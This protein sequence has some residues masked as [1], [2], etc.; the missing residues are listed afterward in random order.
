MSNILESLNP[1]Q[2]RAATIIDGPLLILAGAG[3]GKTKTITHRIAYMVKE[4]NIEP[5]SILAVTFTNKA[6]KEM[7]DRI[8]KLIGNDAKYMS[9]STFHSFG[10]KLLR[11]YGEKIGYDKNFNIYDSGDQQRILRKIM[12]NY[13]IESDSFK[14]AKIASKISNLKEQGIEPNEYESIA[15]NYYEECVSEI[16]VEYQ[17][18]LRKNN[19][20]DF[21]DILVYTKKLMENEEVLEKIQKKYK[22]VMIDEYQDTNKM[23]Y[24]I[25]NKIA[26]KNK[27]LCVVGDEDQSIYGFRGADI[28]NILN[29]ELDYKNTEVIKLERNYRSTSIILEAANILIKNNKTSKGKKLWTENNRGSKIKLFE[30]ED[31]REEAAYVIKEIKKLSEETYDYKDFCILYRTNAQSR[32][33]EDELRVNNINYKIFGGI[34]FYQRKEIKD[35]MAFL[36]V[37]NNISDDMS[38]MRIMEMYCQGVGEK[39]IEKIEEFAEKYSKGLYF[40]MQEIENIKGVNGKAKLSLQKLYEIITEGR[41]MSKESGVEEII[42]YI[43]KITKYTEKLK[44]QNEEEKIANVYELKNSIHDM[45]KINGKMNLG[46]YLEKISLITSVDDLEEDTNYVKLMT[47]H[48]SKGLEFPVVFVV[49]MEDELFPGKIADID[50]DRVEEERRLCYVA[51]TRAEERLY[52]T[53]ARSRI[54]YN[55]LS[56]MR[57]PSRFICEIPQDYFETEKI[58]LE[59]NGYRNNSVKSFSELKKE[60]E[61]KKD[62]AADDYL[63]KIGQ[64]VTHKKFGE[65]KVKHIEADKDKIK[66][67]FPGYGEKEFKGSAL[68]KFLV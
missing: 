29:F 35:I 62:V 22:Y 58:Y 24:D 8:E 17:K 54:L 23:Q 40:A 45:E 3:S 1:E 20:M 67:F 27:N 68:N 36:N 31:A 47:I 61:N 52:F 30:G 25:V 13:D 34:Q 6:A 5:G 14:P 11:V 28:R 49:G 42:D 33:F 51:I 63:Y 65:G 50:D 15:S 39:T 66:I 9:V 46:E 53:H 7:K 4:K 44:L 10:V 59:M 43:L 57:E 37:I 12:K 48:N 41:Y 2:R 55:T 19:S 32:A 64:Y 38:M 56:S 21:S 18:E 60:I 16:Y 26:C